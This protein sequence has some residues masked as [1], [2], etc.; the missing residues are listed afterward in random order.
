MDTAESV[1]LLRAAFFN[2]KKTAAVGV[3]KVSWKTTNKAMRNELPTSL[4]AFTE[5]PIAGLEIDAWSAHS[6]A[7]EAGEATTHTGKVV[8]AVPQ[9]MA[10][11]P[12]GQNGLVGMSLR[13]PAVL[14]P[15]GVRVASIP[16]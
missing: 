5:E 3:D 16:R 12:V 7:Q 9:P 1:D 2:L 10:K 8:L 6:A 13:R 14:R 15:R 4:A 11:R